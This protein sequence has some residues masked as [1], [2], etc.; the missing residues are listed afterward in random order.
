MVAVKKFHYYLLFVIQR[1]VTTQ[2]C[3]T[4]HFDYK[5]LIPGPSPSERQV[6]RIDPGG[7]RCARTQN[8]NGIC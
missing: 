7:P 4:P 6:G 1:F 8:R 3:C 2:F 5:L